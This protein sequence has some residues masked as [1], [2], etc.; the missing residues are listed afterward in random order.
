MD[1][2]Q[3][4]PAMSHE[5]PLATAEAAIDYTGGAAA[6]EVQATV[7]PD[8]PTV[9][10]T[11]QPSVAPPSGP[12]VDLLAA[13]AKGDIDGMRTIIAGD[14]SVLGMTNPR[15]TPLIV[16]C[17]D[18]LL[19]PSKLLIDA[20]ADVEKAA[21]VDLVTPLFV[22]CEKGHLDCASALL[23]HGVDVNKANM[24][25]ET[26]LFI[27]A[28]YNM[29]ECAKVLLAHGA[30]V[31]T[32]DKQAS[33]TALFCSAHE[34]NVS[35]TKLL[36]ALGA[37][38][39]ARDVNGV[40]PLFWAEAQGHAEVAAL[41]KDPPKEELEM[42]RNQMEAAKVASAPARTPFLSPHVPPPSCL[43]RPLPPWPPPP[44]DGECAPPPGDPD[45]TP[46]SSPGPRSGRLKGWGV[47]QSA[48]ERPVMEPF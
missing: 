40:T 31:G 22:A 15:G 43:P 11:A 16:G 12:L 4:T 29:T 39:E 46:P 24:Y 3:I 8:M 21:T 38:A 1:P 28:R 13:M 5:V 7:V 34:G 33:W 10:A 45:P 35:L 30:E 2:M 9:S 14:M 17:E 6:Q 44:R 27:S 25:G 32:A 18:G 19:E 26:P 42:L 48:R 20:G 37:D 23:A 41:L 47:V 36:L